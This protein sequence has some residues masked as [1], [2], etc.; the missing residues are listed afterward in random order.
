MKVK[1]WR[2]ISIKILIF[3]KAGVVKSIL[4]KVDLRTKKITRD[5]EGY[6]L[7][8]KVSICQ[9]DKRTHNL[10]ASNTEPQIILSKKLR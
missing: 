5:K 7:M 6:Y 3:L 1:V 4:N 8:I 2:K 9:E 10:Y